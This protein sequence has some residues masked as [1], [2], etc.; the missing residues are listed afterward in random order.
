MFCEERESLARS[1]HQFVILAERFQK[2]FI[3]GCKAF[4]CNRFTINLDN[5][6]FIACFTESCY[7]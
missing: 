2:Q 1:W 3:V 5:V 7:R 6:V 4:Y